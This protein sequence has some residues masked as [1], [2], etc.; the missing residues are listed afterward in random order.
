MDLALRIPHPCQLGVLALWLAWPS[1]V[2][3]SAPLV[4]QPD[5]TIIGDSYDDELGTAVAAGGDLNGDG[6]DD[7]VLGVP[8][9]D[10][11]W[12]EAGEV[13]ILFGRTSGWAAIT[14]V[15]LA[16]ATV[17]GENTDDGIG[18]AVAGVGDVNDD[19]LDD[20]LI[21]APYR[22]SYGSSDG[23][24]FLVL[25]RTAGWA[26]G[27]D[28]A[29]TSDASFHGEISGDLAGYAVAGLGD[30]NADSIADFAIGAPY[31]GESGTD[32]GQV[33][34]FFGGAAGWSVGMGADE[35]DASWHG[36]DIGDELGVSIAGVG[37][38]NGD[39]IDDLL[40]GAP[41]NSDVSSSSGKAYLRLGSPA[42]WGTDL[43][44][45]VADAS[46]LG[47]GMD[48]ELGRSVAGAGD[49]DGDGLD[50]LLLGAWEA[51]ETG[52][53]AG[54]VYL[55][56]GATTGWQPDTP[57]ADADVTM[58][59]MSSNDFAGEWIHGG[60]DFNG[61]GLDDIVIAA[62]KNDEA[63]NDAGQAYLI[64]GRAHGWAPA[65]LLDGATASL[66]G[67]DSDDEIQA[68]VLAGD[69][70]G[71]GLDDLVFG[72]PHADDLSGEEGALYL[73]HGFA[74]EDTDGDGF[75]ACGAV[76]SLLDCDDSDAVTYPGAPEL[77]DA[78]DN[79][80]DGEVDE[81]F[82]DIDGDGVPACQGDCND[83][84]PT[85]H[86]GAAEGCDG[87]D[88]DCDGSV[89]ELEI[90]EDEDGY[91]LCANDCDDT[92]GFVYP[93]APEI[94]GDMID[95]DC[96]D[97]LDWETDN[98]GD[99]YAPCADDCHDNDITLGPWD[100]DLDGYSPCDGDCDDTAGTV[101]PGAEE[102]CNGI[103]DD[104]DGWPGVEETDDDADGFMRCEG[105]CADYVEWVNP[106]EVEIP[107]NGV[108]DDCDVE[109]TDTPDADLDG[110]SACY[111]DCDD[112]D[113]GTFP[114]AA[115]ACDGRD[116]N[117]NGIIDEGF[118]RDS[119]GFSSCSDG[120]CK[121]DD[122][123]IYPGAP[124]IPYDGI[125][126]DCDGSDLTDIDADSYPGGNRGADCDDL[127][128]WIHPGAPEDCT[129]GVDADCDGV[130]DAVETDC[131]RGGCSFVGTGP[132][133]GAGLLALLAALSRL[134]R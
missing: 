70:D 74:C 52:T 20:L 121:D 31:N 73:V 65:M 115:E 16:D 110:F 114:D 94:C 99:G 109:T 57:A 105:D 98:D 50:D 71:D 129:D 91:L 12:P 21:G 28:V 122:F 6:L 120:D 82:D 124:E 111:G 90:D 80:C 17:R 100:D 58:F 56:F 128:S 83:Y 51:D 81:D 75:V 127:R 93:G 104:C 41:K 118:D 5:L 34:V 112:D 7:L 43:L 38:V 9:S 126:Q 46:F 60:G 36:E 72:S 92:S 23:E 107:C 8:N 67:G 10:N 87:E 26:I 77:C 1:A 79:D 86:P 59:G 116:N 106:G 22:D 42:G 32:A 69:L 131:V 11:P 54:A 3:A 61:D 33:Y 15:S 39:Q 113:A 97:D 30:V 68:V 125:D 14:D 84:N 47:S 66:M 4:L 123:F 64:L 101:F 35:A 133:P 25:G 48:Y 29:T 95:S 134:R 37:D 89:G 49:V 96:G 40:V 63:A 53:D 2:R 55:V 45:T 117:C 13:Y 103:D 85:I 102:L 19:G 132:G 119:D 130:D 44:V 88:T 62:P 78:L 27:L 24:S 76:P 18:H 108:D